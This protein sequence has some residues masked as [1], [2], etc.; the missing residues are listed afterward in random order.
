MGP[1]FADFPG[2]IC[3][4]TRQQKPAVASRFVQIH[5]EEKWNYGD[6][7]RSQVTTCH[8]KRSFTCPKTRHGWNAIWIS[9]EDV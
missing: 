3:Q 9:F 7:I 5:V 2:S 4:K 6:P 1:T 8:N